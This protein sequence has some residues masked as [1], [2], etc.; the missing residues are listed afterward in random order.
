MS[1]RFWT[2]DLHLGHANIAKYCKRPWL[3]ADDLGPD[4]NWACKEF[5]DACATRMNAGLL[6]NMNSRIKPD[7]T[8]VHV[9]DFCCHGGERGVSGV[10]IKAR[11]WEDQ[12]NGKWIFITGNHDDNN[13]VK[14]GLET[15]IVTI[16]SLKAFVQHR[17]IERACEVPDL[18]SFVICGHVHEHWQTKFIDGILCINVGVDVNR[19]YP[20]DDSEVG[21]LYWRTTRA[22]KGTEACPAKESPSSAPAD[23]GSCAAAAV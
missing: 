23:T 9:G 5:K 18:C 19:F 13:T 20:L 6:H 3:R 7:D 11:E 21:G 15:A 2:S 12:L 4:G 22:L 14:H 17:P 1:K 10:K 16:C 8:V